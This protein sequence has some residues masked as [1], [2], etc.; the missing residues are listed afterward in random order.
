[1]ADQLREENLEAFDHWYED[2]MKQVNE[3]LEQEVLIAM[4]G[5]VNA[6]KSSTIN[7]LVGD[8]VAEVGSKPGETTDVKRYEYR[9][10]IF[11]VDTPGL[12]DVI[13]A[14]SEETIKFYKE[15]D[16]VLFFLNAAGTVLSEGELRSLAE[17]AKINSTILL[18]LNKIDAAEDIPEIVSY[19]KKHTNNKYSIIPIS[20]KTGEN[21][22]DLRNKILDLLKK[23]KKDILFAKNLK[24]KSSTA[25]KWILAATGS[26]ATIGA[27]PLPGA[28]IIPITA[29]QVGMMVK[30]ATLYEKPLS[31]ERAKEL[32]I[33]TVA[34][35]VGKSVF[36][37]IVKTF[38]GI[39]SIAGAGVAGTMTFSLGHAMKYAY[40]HN[41]ELD[42]EALK[43][44]YDM[45]ANRSKDQPSL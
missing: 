41:I 5:D 12:D 18:V 10:R 19:I 32:A 3:Q 8:Q 11:F 14:N 43:S 13:K 28:D 1:M 27:S 34:G 20:S 4:I 39:G 21:I 16:V 6:G 7:K 15:A 30:L 31:K 45:F 26:T 22:D 2:E 35:N 24:I 33:A 25:N 37:Q 29:I 38:P 44:I 42:T 9:S 23:K 17:A 36:R 40:E